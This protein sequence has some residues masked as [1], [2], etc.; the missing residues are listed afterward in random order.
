M[1][2]NSVT[3]SYLQLD[4]TLCGDMFLLLEKESSSITMLNDSENFKMLKHSR[5]I[6]IE[7]SGMI[8]GFSS[9]INNLKFIAAV[10][11]IYSDYYFLTFV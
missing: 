3:F 9:K 8:V 5:N 6:K 7:E 2:G 4:N 10:H 11:T 1:L